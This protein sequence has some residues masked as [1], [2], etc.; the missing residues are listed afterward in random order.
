MSVFRPVIFT[1]WDE[2][3]A[4]GRFRWAEVELLEGDM[5]LGLRRVN[6]SPRWGW[7]YTVLR[8]VEGEG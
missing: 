8:L 7:E 4:E 1:L 3:D 5:V 2:R 6:E